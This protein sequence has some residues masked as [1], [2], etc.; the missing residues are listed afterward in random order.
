MF[1]AT[2]NLVGK[3]RFPNTKSNPTEYQRPEFSPT[4]NLLNAQITRIFSPKFEMYIGGENITGTTQDNPI[5][6]ADN[7][8]NPYFD[9]TMVYAPINGANFYTGLRFKL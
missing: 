7:P 9:S 8:F 1:D 3:Q 5:I 4:T 6:S 2:Y